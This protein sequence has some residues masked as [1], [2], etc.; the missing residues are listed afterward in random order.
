MKTTKLIAAI[1]YLL[2]L[3]TDLIAQTCKEV[4]GYYPN[5]QWYDRTKLV[6]PMNLSYSKYS[7]I[8]Y[9]FFK[10]ETTGLIS[11]TDTWAD[12][13]LLNGQPN[14]A[15]GGYYPNTSIVDRAHKAGTKVMVS[16]GGWSLSDN[17][18]AIAASPFLRAAFAGDCNRLISQY[19]FDGIDIDWEYPGHL[20][21]AGTSGG[22]AA[23]KPNF[24]LFLQQI[25]DSIT[26][27]GTRTG[28][29][30][31]LSACFSANATYAANIEWNK[32]PALLDMVNL[33]TYDFFG[34]WDAIANHNSPLYAPTAGDTGFN[35]NSA[36]TMLTQAYNV[37]ASK[38]NLGVAFYGRT[39]TG[40]TALHQPTSGQVDNSTFSVDAGSPT[41]Y[42]I[43][44][45]ISL[46]D[47]YW[48][49]TAKVPYLLG[50][51]G[52]SAAGTFVSYDDKNSIALKGQYIVN[53]GARGAIIWEITG[54]YMETS[55]GSGI[56]AGT[57]LLDTLNHALCTGTATA[58]ADNEPENY[59]NLFPNP[60]TGNATAALTLENATTVAIEIYNS[61][62]QLI[63]SMAI[64]GQQGLNHL[65]LTINTPGIYSV[66][67]KSNQMLKR[68]VLVVN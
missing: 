32:V 56:V 21:N 9:C 58:I 68:S 42:N 60:S 31:K 50:K 65:P 4:V 48:D 14:Y 46:F 55:S 51:T 38:I 67:V 5:W 2:F 17:F 61:L 53:K 57:S 13:N 11:S 15:Q 23:D 63:S 59:L 26:A 52:G 8:N 41:Y 29:Q 66:V 64:A 47:Y 40:A 18:P 27:L 19:K 44:A 49:N 36:F 24:T 22:G 54:D 33:M 12:D 10:P 7:V 1:F 62:G 28:K 37:P 3:F 6:N 45:N 43:M 16:I 35:L 20:G 39:Q 34:A 30:Y 25:R